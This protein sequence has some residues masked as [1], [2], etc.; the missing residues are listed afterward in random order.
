[1]TIC[2]GLLVPIPALL[3]ACMMPSR[4]YQ[5]LITLHAVC[6]FGTKRKTLAKVIGHFALF[7]WAQFVW[8][9]LFFLPK[10]TGG[11]LGEHLNF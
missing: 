3:L 8:V 9:F 5:R 6:D 1:M 7:S 11:S 10:T 2:Y 4:L